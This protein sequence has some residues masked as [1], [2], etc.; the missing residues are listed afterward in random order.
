MIRQ[1]PFWYDDDAP[2]S[3]EWPIR[4]LAAWERV[5]ELQPGFACQVMW[6]ERTHVRYRIQNC[7]TTAEAAEFARAKIRDLGAAL[8]DLGISAE[9]PLDATE[10]AGGWR[11]AA[12]Y[13]RGASEQGEARPDSARA[14]QRFAEDER[15]PRL[16]ESY[17]RGDDVADY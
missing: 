16:P 11:Q 14:A 15:E 3:N 4:D 10:L 9:Q 1:R 8:D 2:R 5:T 12:A 13:R 7:A 6:R 17:F